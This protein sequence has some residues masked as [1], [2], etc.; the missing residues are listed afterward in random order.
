MKSKEEIE[1]HLGEIS[2]ADVEDLKG[3]II[4]L[5]LITEDETKI[6]LPVIKQ[7]ED[8]ENQ[9]KILKT[10]YYDRLIHLL[11]TDHMI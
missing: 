3:I 9:I 10:K 4:T 7:L 11:K 2:E 8:A 6:S 5:T 1:R